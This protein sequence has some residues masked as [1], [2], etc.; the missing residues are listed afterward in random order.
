M[1]VE[2]HEVTHVEL[3]LTALEPIYLIDDDDDTN[4]DPARMPADCAEFGASAKS[5][6]RLRSRS[7]SPAPD[8]RATRAND[9]HETGSWLD[10]AAE[11]RSR[12]I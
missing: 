11:M 4:G 10:L 12:L 7:F 2:L 1:P 9:A 5:S 3:V 6:S 8:L